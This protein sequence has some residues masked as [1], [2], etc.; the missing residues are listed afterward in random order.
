MTLTPT[1]DAPAE[2]VEFAGELARDLQKV[3]ALDGR[4]EIIA[5]LRMALDEAFEQLALRHYARRSAA[6][7]KNDRAA[8]NEAMLTDDRKK[9]L[10]RFM[11]DSPLQLAAFTAV[12]HLVS[13]PSKR[14]SKAVHNPNLVP[15]AAQLADDIAIADQAVTMLRGIRW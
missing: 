14:W 8:L 2:L 1:K 7:A 13:V 11:A 5:L 3:L 4:A 15:D 6:D 10:R 12:L 9:V